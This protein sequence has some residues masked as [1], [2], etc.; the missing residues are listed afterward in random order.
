ME[1]NDELDIAKLVQYEL[2]A[3]I[4]DDSIDDINDDNQID[5][6]EIE[7]K[8][9][10]NE[11]RQILEREM[12]E[13]LAAFENEVKVNLERYEIDYSEIDELLQ[14]PINKYENDIE[15]NVARECG[16]EREE[17]ER[18][19]QSINAEEPSLNSSIDSD[20]TE[21]ED[22]KI[23]IIKPDVPIIDT[24][25]SVEVTPR[26]EEQEDPNK[27]I[28][29]ERI[30]ES[31]RRMLDELALLEQRRKE[32]EERYAIVLQEQQARLAEEYRRLQ[33]T[34]DESA[35][36]TYN[37]KLQFETLCREQE[38]LTHDRENKMATIIQAWY[39]GKR[40]YRRYHGEIIKRAAPTLR[41]IAKKRKKKEQEDLANAAKLA[42][43][44][45][46]NMIE[47]ENDHK[48]ETTSIPL[49]TSNRISSPLPD[50]GNKKLNQ[51]QKTLP[52]TETKEIGPSKENSIKQKKIQ[53]K[54][55]TVSKQTSNSSVLTTQIVQLENPIDFIPTIIPEQR[56]I[57]SSRKIHIENNDNKSGIHQISPSIQTKEQRPKSSNKRQHSARS[58]RT[59]IS[60][61]TND[62]P[63]TNTSISSTEQFNI[64][65]IE[66]K[67]SSR[68]IT[69]SDTF[70]K[71][72]ESPRPSIE[73]ISIQSKSRNRSDT[74]H[75]ETENF[76]TL[77]IESTSIAKSIN[78]TPSPTI[79]RSDTF[80][81]ET[82]NFSSIPVVNTSI[83]KSI[84]T[85]LPSPSINRSDTFVNKSE[86]SPS[87]PIKTI[88][89]HQSDTYINNSQNISS[90]NER[91]S[92]RK[93]LDTLPIDLSVSLKQSEI[94]SITPDILS[95]SR[96]S[97][98]RKVTK[99]EQ[100]STNITNTFL[101]EA[102]RWAGHIRD[103]TY[104]N[105][106]LSTEEINQEI[107]TRKM[108]ITFRKLPDID[109]QI[110]KKATKNQS[111]K[112]IRYLLLEQILTPCSLSLIGTMYLNLTH[113]ILRQCKLVQLIGLDSC[114]LLTVLDIEGNW[115]EQIH[116]HLNHLE[117]LNM[118]RNR[119][120][121]LLSINT[122][123]LKYLDVSKNRLTRLNGLETL[124]NLN[125][126]LAT[127]N[128]LLTTIGLQGCTN[129]LYIDIS[130]N[131][132]VEME[133][134]DQCPLLITLKANSNALIQIPN[135]FNAILLNE[136]DLSS[137][138]LTS[139]DELSIGSWLPYLTHL[140]LSN[141]NLQEL[142]S[143]KLPSLIELDLAF[144]QLSDIS[145]LKRFIKTCPLLSRI[146]LEQNPVLC[147]IK[148]SL[149]IEEKSCQNP[150]SILPQSLNEKSS[151]S[152]ELY[153]NFLSNITSMFIKLRQTIEQYQIEPIHL[154]KS[155]HNQCQQYYEQKIIEPIKISEPILPVTNN[156]KNISADE[157][158]IIRLQ[159]HWRRRLIE[160]NLSLKWRAAQKI[161]A[162]WRGHAVRQRI[163]TVRRLFSQ[164]QQQTF[165]EIDLAQFD[166]DEAAFDARFQR[167]R[168][169]SV[170]VQQ[171]WQPQAQ[172]FSK[173]T[174]ITELPRPNSSRSSSVAS[175]R[176]KPFIEPLS[177]EARTQ[178]IT[179]EWGFAPSSSTAALM[180]KRAERMKWNAERK[181]KREHL[182]AY[183]RLQKARQNEQ[184]PGSLRLARRQASLTNATKPIEQTKPLSPPSTGQ[185]RSNRVYEWVHT[186]VARIDDSSLGNV[187]TPRNERKRLPSIDGSTDLI[188]RTGA[189]ETSQQQ[190]R[191]ST[192]TVS[193]RQ[194]PPLLP[195]I[196]GHLP[197]L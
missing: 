74:F 150:L 40:I 111:S 97:T 194:P 121:S 49:P 28:Y 139:F 108:S 65:P 127:S 7:D 43:I 171:V 140:R 141:N 34:L 73:N 107:R 104:S 91:I 136:L 189:N 89:Q 33:V 135:L 3:L 13:R 58:E 174:S 123:C 35:R 129:L 157:Q 25:K 102:R 103:I 93:S 63:S 55:Q 71:N 29:D 95:T 193:V 170:R 109:S 137:N 155:I 144:N 161:Q 117:Y 67:I 188:N 116:I 131:H 124:S 99:E 106:I 182:D 62:I 197:R 51:P 148:D 14:K 112:E 54:S 142:S 168:T 159:A 18:I 115:L 130:D 94:I 185:S 9:I 48:I 160:R 167:P 57:S 15:T 114:T 85:A 143:I 153:L 181:H 186:E 69:R 162:R 92:V 87:P 88:S 59:Q 154:I 70:E 32:E 183:Q 78:T 164:Q 37:E 1:T 179:N 101:N 163:R 16:I 96:I 156:M 50:T 66:S 190:Q 169:P 53:Q 133:Q 149:L 83:V 75:K 126:L 17:L 180:L 44:Q 132:L 36:Q 12:H 64:T 118:S 26:N 80:H 113:L 6:E 178:L 8:Q 24:D 72:F 105:L 192:S 20:L 68:S 86:K 23:E 81:K 77:P 138:S 177:I 39:R 191:W 128:Q 122:P 79:N 90:S 195:P 98:P 56:T 125:I 61:I 52:L 134:V 151:Q 152:I 31:H 41:T 11:T 27:K 84:D 19:L 184:P 42:K 30:A 166:F 100:Y 46:V 45:E 82:E 172:I 146:N 4:L 60:T 147:D 173:T 21:Y 2:D 47:K 165:D 22:S 76:S 175:S 120:T 110:L 119:I 38:R 196:N 176:A 187:H 158:C 10:I 5:T 145:I